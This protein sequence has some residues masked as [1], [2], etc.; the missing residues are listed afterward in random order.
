[1]YAD[2]RRLRD[3]TNILLREVAHSLTG[4]FNKYTTSVI[5]L[6]YGEWSFLQTTLRIHPNSILY[7]STR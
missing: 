1:M 3:V 5:H 7:I 4:L 2:L 6:F